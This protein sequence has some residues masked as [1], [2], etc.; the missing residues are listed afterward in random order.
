MVYFIYNLK[1]N[2][3]LGEIEI[4]LSFLSVADRQLKSLSLYSI[5]IKLGRQNKVNEYA[6]IAQHIVGNIKSKK[7]LFNLTSKMIRIKIS[8]FL[9][10]GF[11]GYFN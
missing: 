8:L 9:N 7:I 5:F 11:S 10:R 2:D 1:W 4:K 6:S 3:C